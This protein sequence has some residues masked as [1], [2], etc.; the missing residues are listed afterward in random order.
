MDDNKMKKSKGENKKEDLT[1]KMQSNDLQTARSAISKIRKEGQLVDIPGIIL[2]YRLQEKEA[3]KREIHSLLCDIQLSGSSKY[4]IEAIKDPQNR[5]ILAELLSICWES[6]QDYT[7]YLEVF[8][9]IF[10]NEDY[11]ASIEAFT[12]IEKIFLDYDI[13]EE[14]LLTTINLIKTSYPDLT[15][16]KRDLALVLLDTLENQIDQEKQ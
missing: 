5:I 4:F 7:G 6:K 8:I 14:K 1:V 11:R 9:S 2:A 10:L 15:E 13:S 16:E 3:L 12:I